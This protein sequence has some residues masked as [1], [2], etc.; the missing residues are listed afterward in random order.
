MDSN[1][2]TTTILEI[3]QNEGIHTTCSIFPSFVPRAAITFSL[4]NACI[5]KNLKSLNC[6]KNTEDNI[7]ISLTTKIKKPYPN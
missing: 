3:P 2:K 1:L 7:H 6:I 5:Q 4:V